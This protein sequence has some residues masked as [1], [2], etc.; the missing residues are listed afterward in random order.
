MYIYI[1]DIV[2]EVTGTGTQPLPAGISFRRPFPTISPV[3]G[4]INA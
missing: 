4:L 1:Y 2:D 3:A